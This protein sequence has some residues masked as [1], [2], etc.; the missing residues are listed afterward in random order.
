VRHAAA[1]PVALR[2]N[3]DVAITLDKKPDPAAD[4]EGVNG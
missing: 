3:P 4:A 2:A 1:R